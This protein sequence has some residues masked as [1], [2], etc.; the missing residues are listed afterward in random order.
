MTTAT[1]ASLPL[2]RSGRPLAAIRAA[3]RGLW[4][5]LARLGEH[6]A[7]SEVARL[8]VLRGHQPSGDFDTDMARLTAEYRRML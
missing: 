2:L 5:A 8:L 6:R 3:G 1:F 7:A 4:H